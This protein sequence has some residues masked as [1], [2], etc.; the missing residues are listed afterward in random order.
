MNQ[1]ISRLASYDKFLKLPD[2]I[3]RLN[4]LL[5]IIDLCPKQEVL[6]TNKPLTVPDSSST[7]MEP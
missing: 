5:F 6:P 7:P 2:G 1:K 4:P 3:L